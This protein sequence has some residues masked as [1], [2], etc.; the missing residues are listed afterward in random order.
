MPS[1]VFAAARPGGSLLCLWAPSYAHAIAAR[2]SLIPFLGLV[3]AGCATWDRK[4]NALV[5]VWCPERLAAAVMAA[6]DGF[7]DVIDWPGRLPISGAWV[8]FFGEAH[9][10][11]QPGDTEHAPSTPGPPARPEP[12]R[13]TAGAGIPD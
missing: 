10:L 12:G 2:R 7:G 3:A 13:A 6:L 1:N 9:L 11:G 4:P 8:M 5:M